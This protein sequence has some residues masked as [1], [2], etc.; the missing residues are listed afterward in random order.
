MTIG[1]KYITNSVLE[2]LY[3]FIAIKGHKFCLSVYFKRF[4]GLRQHLH[5]KAMKFW[6][7]ANVTLRKLQKPYEGNMDTLLNEV[8]WPQS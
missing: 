3:T 8:S 2:E 6:K 4:E 7:T 5:I 1:L